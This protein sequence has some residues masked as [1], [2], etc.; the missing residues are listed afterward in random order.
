MYKTILGISVAVLLMSSVKGQEQKK[1]SIKTQIL[2]EVVVSDSRF[3]LKRENSGKTIIKINAEELQHNQGRSL[4][5][6]INKKSGIEIAGSRGRE[7]TILGVFA[8]GGRGRQVLVLVDGVR[9]S[10]PSSFSQEYDLRLLSAAN[11]ESVEILKGAAST[12]YGTNAATAVISITTKKISERKVSLNVQSSRGTNQTSEDQNYNLSQ[13][14][15]SV[16]I[17]GTLDK[18]TYQMSF[19]N[20]YSDGLSAIITS[21]NQEDSYKQINTDIKLGYQVS[22]DFKIAVYANQTK[23]N[24]EYDESFGLLDADYRFLSEQKR[25]GLT[26]EYKYQQGSVH[27]NTAY[28]KYDSENKSAFPSMFEGDNYVVDVYNKLSI[29]DKLFT[30]VGLNYIKDQSTFD[31]TKN[32]NV[33][34]PYTNMVYVSDI[35]FNLNLGARLNNHSEYGSHFVY[36]VNPSFAIKTEEGYLKVLTTYATSFITPSLTQLFGNF[37]ANPDLEP[38]DNRTI[39][40]GLEYAMNDKLR[41]S[42]VYFN[43]KEENFV[44]YDNI[45]GTYGNSSETID[46]Q[47]AE[48]ELNWQPNDKIRLSSNYTFT[49]RKGDA[50]IRLPKHKVNASLGY[51]FTRNTYASIDYRY[52]GQRLDTDFNTFSNVALD[53][54]SLLDVYAEHD[55][56]PKKL[57]FFMGVSNVFN[58]AYT[59]IIGFTTRGRN[60]RAGFNITL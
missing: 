31:T 9:V 19:S 6:I 8:R 55:L 33:I 2:N 28:T 17:G 27:L 45:T 38:E 40:G 7:G 5:E 1:D 51:A 34:D 22:E 26:S 23:L 16:L 41:V 25:A 32:F 48:I 4:A 24:T 39:E 50:A 13:A 11:I 10:D 56:L 43:R 47:G 29:N 42:A 14:F 21:Q 52:T 36:N 3:E 59:E 20:R 15:N 58:V 49:E 53:P 18:F 60:I 12:L 30:I 54:F 46:A 57:K 44:F 35:G 37:G